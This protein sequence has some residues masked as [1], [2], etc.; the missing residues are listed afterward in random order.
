MTPELLEKLQYFRRFG[1]C[2]MSRPIKQELGVHYKQITG[3]ALNIDCGACVI[4]AMHRVSAEYKI[5]P[6]KIEKFKGVK[7]TAPTA[8]EDLQKMNF[9]K[10]KSLANAKAKELGIELAKD[11]NKEELINILTNGSAE[12][13]T[14]STGENQGNAEA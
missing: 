3:G 11:A 4:Q 2:N 8:T 1:S 12:T 9:M 13:T 7:Q 5:K 10:L 14:E 6:V